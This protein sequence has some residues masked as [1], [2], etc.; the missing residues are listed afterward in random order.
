MSLY[1]WLKNLLQSEEGQ[2]LVEYA[3]LLGL[4][5]IICVV[6]LTAAGTQVRA[7]WETIS[8]TLGTAVTA[9]T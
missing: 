5:S 6:A 4:I 8:T 9:T 7:I 2:D 1:L 3:L